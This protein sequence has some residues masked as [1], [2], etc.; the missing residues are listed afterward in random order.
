MKVSA[1]FLMNLYVVLVM[2]SC[3]P[4]TKQVFVQKEPVIE[5]EAKAN[6]DLAQEDKV[7]Q[8][9]TVQE[10]TNGKAVLRLTNGW[11][12]STKAEAMAIEKGLPY[13][14]AKMLVE[15]AL[16]QMS[17][18]LDDLDVFTVNADAHHTLY[19]LNTD[20]ISLTKGTV[21]SL[22]RSI[23][24]SYTTYDTEWKDIKITPI[25]NGYK[26]DPAHKLVFFKYQFQDVENQ[27]D[28]VYLSTY[29]MS[30]PFRSFIGYEISDAPEDANLYLWS[31]REP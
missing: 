24:E 8:N 19:L 21:S 22:T 25:D 12:R 26:D 16:S 27:E 1:V 3:K 17:Y 5:Q 20:T 23:Q 14:R 10:M 11:Q 15:Q 9:T 30:T 28:I 6:V 13:D 18:N 2:L 4:E 7:W 31:T 29:F